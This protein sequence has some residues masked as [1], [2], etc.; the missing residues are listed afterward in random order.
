[1]T[2]DDVQV[3]GV[4]Q[5]HDGVDDDW[6]GGKNQLVKFEQMRHTQLM[7]TKSVMIQMVNDCESRSVFHRGY[8]HQL[9]CILTHDH[10]GCFFKRNIRI[11]RTH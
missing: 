6:R 7:M 10:M 3:E 11:V 8:H 4:G 5:E 1:M 9:K 2:V